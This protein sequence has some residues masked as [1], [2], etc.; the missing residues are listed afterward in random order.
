MYS[1]LFFYYFLNINIKAILSF[2]AALFR[3]VLLF[4]AAY[5]YFHLIKPEFLFTQTLKQ[6]APIGITADRG[7]THYIKLSVLTV[8]LTRVN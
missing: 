4:T 7:L 2:I 8:K 3:Q 1:A 6:K 5:F